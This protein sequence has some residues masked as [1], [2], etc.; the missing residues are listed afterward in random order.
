MIKRKGEID[1]FWIFLIAIFV[2]LPAIKAIV[3]V[4]EDEDST[5]LKTSVKVSSGKKNVMDI[6]NNTALVAIDTEIKIPITQGSMIVKKASPDRGDP[7]V[8]KIKGKYAIT[9]FN[10][11]G[12]WDVDM[13]DGDGI[14][15]DWI[16][17]TVY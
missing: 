8:I 13:S 4:D 15:V 11:I 9:S 7:E 6:K 2:V 16:K 17:V 14:L 5:G 3:G 12:V 10:Q 1:G